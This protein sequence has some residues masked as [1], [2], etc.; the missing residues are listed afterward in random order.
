LRPTATTATNLPYLC[1][2]GKQKATTSKDTQ[3]A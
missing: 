2:F 3:K 1:H